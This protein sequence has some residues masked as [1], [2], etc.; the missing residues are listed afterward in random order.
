MSG[1]FLVGGAVNIAAALLGYVL[2]AKRIPW[3]MLGSVF[4]VLSILNAGKLNVRNE[5][6]ARDNQSLKN[7]SIT[8][9]PGMMVDWFAAGIGGTVSKA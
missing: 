3:I 9:V 5:Y 7:S 2:A 8:Q 1:L 4:A 6:W